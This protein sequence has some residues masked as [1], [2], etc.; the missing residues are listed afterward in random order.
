ML[1]ESSAS[2]IGTTMNLSEYTATLSGCTT[3]LIVTSET[4][5]R[6]SIFL[7]G[8]SIIHVAD[9]IEAR[10]ECEFRRTPSGHRNA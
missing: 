6:T 4:L 1:S 3:L 9:M 10:P 2:L 7:I 5:R 8:P